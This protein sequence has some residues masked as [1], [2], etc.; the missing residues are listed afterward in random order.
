MS[1]EERIQQ[2]FRDV[3]DQ[4]DLVV[5]SASSPNE[6]EAWDSLNH[7][8]IIVA[9]QSEFHIKFALAEMQSLM[10]VGAMIAI[11]KRKAG[12]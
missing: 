7:I 8:N 9:I 3:L 10:N 4:A 6:I 5:T 1:V 12:L 2:I 11:I